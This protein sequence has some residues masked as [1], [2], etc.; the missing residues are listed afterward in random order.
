MKDYLIGLVVTT[1]AI[2]AP[3][4]AIFLVTGILIF[5][6]LILG[7]VAAKKRG[8]TI[9]SAGL[10]RTAT[11]VFVY[12]AAII[13]GFLVETFMLEGFL[14]IS[15]ITAGLI[16]VVELTSILENLNTING[17]PV[18]KKLIEKLGSVNDRK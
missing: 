16:S 2:F 12:K 14:P 17:S 7:I 1:A 10:R 5:S 6:D 8:E 11:K 4:K 3:I 18:F 13:L 9:S 15:K